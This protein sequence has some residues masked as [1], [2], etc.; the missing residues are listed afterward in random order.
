MSKCYICGKDSSVFYSYV[1]GKDVCPECHKVQEEERVLRQADGITHPSGFREWGGHDLSELF[2][3]HLGRYKKEPNPESLKYMEMAFR[4]A[5]HADHG[6]SS[7][8]YHAMKWAGI[9]LYTEWKRWEKE[10]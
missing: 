1:G 7:S 3:I 4:W 6:L 8:F 10:D 9:D 5:C 2:W